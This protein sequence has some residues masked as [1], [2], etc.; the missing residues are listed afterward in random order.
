VSGCFLHCHGKYFSTIYNIFND[1][2]VD[3]T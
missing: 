3:V 1:I 2:G